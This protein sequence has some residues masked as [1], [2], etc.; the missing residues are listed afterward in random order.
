[1]SLVVP[2]EEIFENK[3]GLLAS[4]TSWERVELS[5]V[6]KILNGFPFKSTLFNTSKGFPVIRIRD[7]TKGTTETLFDGEFPPEYIVQNGELLIGMDGIF[8]CCEWQGGEAGLN[9]RVCKIIP[10]EKHLDRKFLL[11]GLNGYLKAIEDATS[12]VTVGHL[13]SRDVLRIPFPLPPLNEQHRIVAK[14]EAVLG[15]VDACQQR[16]AKIPVILKRF[17]QAV[18]AAACSGRLTADWREEQGRGEGEGL[19]AGWVSHCVHEIAAEIRTGPFGSALHKTDYVIGGIPVINP[20]HIVSGKIVASTT[21]TIS[22]ETFKRLSDYALKKGDII[23]ARRGELGRCAVVS[24]NEEGYLC[25]TGSA[26]LRLKKLAFPE[27]LKMVI[28]SPETRTYLSDGSVGTTMDNLNQRL[29]AALPLVLPPLSEQQEIV[30]RVEALF[31]LADQL[32]ARYL[33]AKAHVDRLTQSI[34]AKAFRGELVPQDENDEPAAALLERIRAVGATRR[35]AQKSKA[36]SGRGSASPLRQPAARNR[37]G[38][39]PAPT[40]MPLVAETPASYSRNIPQAILA[41]MQPGIEYSRA[42]I[43]DT[44]GLST[45]D[46]NWAIRQLK[47]EGKVVQR[48]ERRGARYRRP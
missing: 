8:R 22:S 34:L 5:E 33:K 47:E 35:V 27:Y 26:I 19:P 48:G 37:A 1:L 20:M 36:T 13:S 46:W 25:G 44:L 32:E 16:L 43:A 14:L 3:T 39:K 10:N 2:F 7:L 30:R 31:T 28:S 45:S 24:Q 9:Q 40:V 4:H 12:S 38:L 21:V 17:R 18:L 15:K 42:D 11:Y 41:H 6:C 23:L 29:F